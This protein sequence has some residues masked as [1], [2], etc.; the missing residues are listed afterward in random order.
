[1]TSSHTHG[2][3]NSS[4][5]ST[6]RGLW[7]IKWSFI[8]L[9]ITAL[10]Q[11]V[12][13]WRSGSAALLADTI[14][15]V[16]DAATAIPLWFAFRLARLKPTKQFTYGYARVEDLAGVVVVFVILLSAILAG[17]TALDRM[18]HP[19]TVGHLWAVGT[20]SVVG[21]LGNEAVA[22]LRIN[23]GKQIGS[24]ALVA[25]GY[26]ARVDGLTSLAVLCGAVGVALG[27]PLADAL[28]GL[29]ISL[30]IL[31]IAWEAGKG[32]FSRLLDRVDGEIVDE[33]TRAVNH[34]EGVCGIGEVRVRWAGHR[35][36]AEVNVVV[37]ADL[38]V[39][40]GHDIAKDVQHRLLH[41]LPYLSHATIHIDP[42]SAS[43]ERYHRV[44]GHSHDATPPHS[45]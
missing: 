31:H 17:Y 41:H 5:L 6:Q 19:R 29:L 4:L 10:F 18:L 40:Q 24:A 14:H 39:E 20:A 21:C 16:G 45:H 35:L 26:H 1:M 22:L 7:A 33:L 30:V 44:T 27:Y 37:R 2:T 42:A 11:A 15:N 34:A 3:I 9:L 38:S 8:G 43:G 32:V 12:V 23:I 28:V 25:D 36:H 13:V